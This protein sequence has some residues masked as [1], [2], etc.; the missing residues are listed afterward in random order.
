MPVIDIPEIAQLTTHEKILLV[1]DLWESITP[2][3]K[4]LSV[5]E[6]HQDELD[7]RLRRHEANPGKLLTLEEL[8]ERIEARK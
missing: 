4:A 3:A 8:Q 7:R 6:S 2:E 1:E 5:P